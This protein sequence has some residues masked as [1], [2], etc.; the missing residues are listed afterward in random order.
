MYLKEIAKPNILFG[1]LTR[2]QRMMEPIQIGSLG[3]FCS[4]QHFY[5]PNI[6]IIIIIHSKLRG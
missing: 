1:L 2:C 3:A 5:L 6:I 4:V